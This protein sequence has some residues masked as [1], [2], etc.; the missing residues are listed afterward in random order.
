MS[1]LQDYSITC[2]KSGN[3]ILNF[4][5]TKKASAVFRLAGTSNTITIDEDSKGE[6]SFSKNY[7]NKEVNFKFNF[8]Q[9]G[10][11]ERRTQPSGNL[12]GPL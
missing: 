4:N 5:T 9:P 6:T 2:D 10:T 11:A 3:Y 12:D 7:G 1:L 8:D